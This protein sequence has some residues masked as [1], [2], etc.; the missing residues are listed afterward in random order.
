MIF[1]YMNEIQC[2]LDYL[3]NE[4]IMKVI[5]PLSDHFFI[6]L[7]YILSTLCVTSS[8]NSVTMEE[9]SAITVS[10][11]V[12]SKGQPVNDAEV[13][14]CIPEKLD[15]TN[16][17][18]ER[19]SVTDDKGAFTFSISDIS[20]KPPFPVIFVWKKGHALG[21]ERITEKSPSLSVQFDLNDPEPVTGFIKNESGE[22]ISQATVTPY[23]AVGTREY[24]DLF[25]YTVIPGTEAL[26]GADGSFSLE[27]L[28]AGMSVQLRISAEGYARDDRNPIRAGQRDFPFMLAPEARIAGQVM[29]APSGTPLA[30]VVIHAFSESNMYSAEPHVAKSSTDGGFLLSGLAPG[31]YTVSVADMPQSFRDRVASRVEHNE[32]RSGETTRIPDVTLI[33]GAVLKGRLSIRETGDPLPAVRMHAFINSQ[34]K[35]TTY[36]DAVGEYTFRCVPGTVRIRPYP[37][38]VY[39]D[40]DMEPRNRGFEAA[41]G[42][43]IRGLDFTFENGDP[44]VVRALSPEDHPVPY[45]KLNGFSVISETGEETIYL[46]SK[47]QRLRLIASREDLHLRGESVTTNITPDM[48]LD[49]LMTRYETTQVH[50]R[51]IDR[52]GEPVPFAQ[53]SHRTK[54][55]DTRGPWR[56]SIRAMTDGNGAFLADSL[57]VGNENIIVIE[58]E[59]FET[60]KISL[61]RQVEEIHD[62]GEISL[63]ETSGWLG[64]VVMDKNGTP[65][66]GADVSVHSAF[67]SDGMGGNSVRDVTDSDGR[68][69]L[70]GLPPKMEWMQVHHSEYYGYRGENI[71]P[72][73]TR[74]IVLLS[75]NRHLDGRVLDEHGHPLS[76]V[77]ISTEYYSGHAQNTTSDAHGRFTLDGLLHVT[78]NII[79]IRWGWGQYHF[80]NIPTNGSWDFVL[81][82]PRD[83]LGGRV[84]DVI[85]HPVADARV[86][87]H[88]VE[89]SHSADGCSMW[90]MAQEGM[91]NNTFFAKTDSIGAFRF[92]GIMGPEVSIEVFAQGY[93]DME[94][95]DITT[96]RDDHRIVL[97]SAQQDNSYRPKARHTGK[98]SDGDPAT[99]LKVAEWLNDDPQ[100]LADLRG[101]IIILDFWSIHDNHSVHATRLMEALQQEYGER[102]LVI[103][104]IHENTENLA[105]VNDCINKRNL[106][107]SIGIDTQPRYQNGKGRTFE[108]YGIQGFEN[109][110]IIDREGRVLLNT[111]IYQMEE[112]VLDLIAN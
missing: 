64:G 65:V 1:S 27:C 83:F 87:I 101:K 11:I 47:R 63:K 103:M 35:L 41:N 2:F 40:I 43:T 48:V 9:K 95:I 23:I 86:M 84:I 88:G 90:A 7:F 4:D 75:P 13:Y 14:L 15:R 34:F 16:P 69:R 92:D 57:V 6:A 91:I 39:D 62:I 54:R 20:I 100:A 78:E 73:T 67:T 18:S 44:V 111:N 8:A 42:D 110:I 56:Q 97:D 52:S 50:G 3:K 107:H 98:V 77:Y 61:D 66:S 99:P 36:T 10:G 96:N 46:S 29:D 59:G 102:G 21:V 70:E 80:H 53:V 37:M 31:M 112:K 79:V 28:P 89:F 51:V 55:P 94:F 19:V 105:A 108:A 106:R 24:F 5:N 68:Y 30:G 33:R 17:Q 93:D 32:A 72:N 104:G 81:P 45:A 25:V 22:G 58:K 85:G 109:D 76:D 49:I 12:F 74:N 26:S 82:E 60:A 38:N 71:I